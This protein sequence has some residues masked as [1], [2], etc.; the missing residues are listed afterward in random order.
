[1]SGRDDRKKKGASTLAAPVISEAKTIHFVSLGCPK[2]RVD[3]EV[4][5]GVARAKG[6]THVEEAS[7]AEVIVVNTCGFIGE[8]KKESID[9]ILEMAGLKEDGVCKR[10]V[11]SGC[12]SQRHPDELAKEMPEVDHFLGSSDMLKLGQVLDGQAERI[13]VGNPADWVIRASDPRTLS[14]PGGSAYVKIA[15]GCNR[16]CSFCVIPEM[17]GQQRS[18]PISDVVEEV[19]RLVDA[20]VR[21]VNLISQ[22]TIAYGRDL[23]KI[24]DESTRADLADLAAAVADVPGLHWVRLFYLYPE[25]MNDRLIDL[26][27]NHPRVVPYVDMPLQHA[28]DAMLKRMRRG[29][30]IGR[31]KRVVETLR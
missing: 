30:G 24:V 16:T 28:A 12:L 22:D 19:R 5:L 8:A 2:N 21:E 15:E 1:M 13:L 26:L 23:P 29:H 27:A 14:T 25:T 9:A 31:Q 20:G 10:L 6:F 18:R 7:E 3:S 17:R 4:M 11:V